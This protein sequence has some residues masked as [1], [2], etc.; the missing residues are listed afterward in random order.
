MSPKNFIC[1]SSHMK[2]Q[3][4]QKIFKS[5][6]EAV[7]IINRILSDQIKKQELDFTLWSL[8]EKIEYSSALL[9]IIYNLSDYYPD[10]SQIPKENDPRKNLEHAQESID[11]ALNHIEDTPKLAYKKLKEASVYL[12][13]IKKE[14]RNKLTRI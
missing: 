13:K 1:W 7:T 2:E 3:Y 11:H 6:Q 8:N 5:L 10:L 9:A 4:N 12:K 14:G